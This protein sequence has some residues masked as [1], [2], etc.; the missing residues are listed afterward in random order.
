[1]LNLIQEQLKHKN[2]YNNIFC[3]DPIPL[4]DQA[5]PKII[6]Y[7]EHKT[8][9][10]EYSVVVP[11]FNQEEIIEKNILSI[12]FNMDENFE[13]IIIL[14]FCIDNTE[15]IL[16]NLFKN[17]SISKLIRTIII[18]QE[19]PVFE[20]TCDNM[21]FLIASGKYILE[22][23]ADMEMVE[24]GFNNKLANGLKKYEDI[25]AISGRCTHELGGGLGI[26]KLG[27]LLEQPLSSNLNKNM[28]YMYGTC[29]RGPLLLDKQKLKLM[30][31]MDEQHFFLH[32]SDHDLFARAYY[33][34]GWRCGYIPI[35]FNSPLKNGST[36]KTLN[37][38]AKIINE[39]AYNLKLKRCIGGFLRSFPYNK[40]KIPIEIRP[41]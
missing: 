16:L 11:V 37:N 33:L 21:G 4:P 17:I 2:Y 13:I 23:Q 29:N 31:Y 26:G 25:I 12:I 24:Y 10:I 38:E 27:E 34:N 22:I 40:N 30:K 41:L 36:R 18:K 32:D 20:T 39:T 14:D 19:T 7:K 5:E 1:M 15:L 6:F 9:N 28:I 3:G 8:E 35:E